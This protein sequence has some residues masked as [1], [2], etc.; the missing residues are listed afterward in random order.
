MRSMRGAV[1]TGFLQLLSQRRKFAAVGLGVVSS[2]CGES[3][4]SGQD[5]LLKAIYKREFVWAE[6]DRGRRDHLGKQVTEQLMLA[7]HL[8]SKWTAL[9]EE[10]GHHYVDLG[11]ST[12]NQDGKEVVSGSATAQ[13][14]P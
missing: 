2:G 11:L 1:S 3:A 5:L 8:H 6:V 7:K 13:I 10:G 9:R 14:D 4:S 12:T